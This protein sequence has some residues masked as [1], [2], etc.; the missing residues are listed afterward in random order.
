MSAPNV[1]VDNQTKK[2]VKKR[3]V[4][5][6]P[7]SQFSNSF[8]LSWTQALYVL[9]ESGYQVVISPATSSHVAFARMKT[10]GLNVMRG[11]DQ[12]PFN[13]ELEYDVF[14]SIDSDIVF[15]PNLLLELIE[16][17]DAE[18]VVSGYYLMA[19]GRNLAVV[20]DWSDE[21]FLKNGTFQFLTLEDVNTWVKDNAEDVEVDV[22]DANGNTVKES[23]KKLTNKFMDVN[24]TGLGFFACRKEV[25]DSLK[26]PFF[27]APLQSI[28][29]TTADGKTLVDMC[30]EDVAF[31]KNIREAGYKIQLHMGLRV[32]HEKPVVL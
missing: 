15:T 10:L 6:L 2:P 30:S 17:T 22:Q 23:R 12:K 14:V 28:D 18:P 13:G 9:W 16:S 8:L 7:G 26:Y 29:G 3:V 27:Y 20:K 21:Y 32:G 1:T 19:D 24:Y 5:G 4:I 25:L 31:S 11:Q